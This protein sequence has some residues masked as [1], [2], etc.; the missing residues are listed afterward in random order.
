MATPVEA[1][2]GD[3]RVTPE[4]VAIEVLFGA[5][6]AEASRKRPFSEGARERLLED[7]NAAFERL[8]DLSSVS[9]LRSRPWDNNL[10]VARRSAVIWW[11][12]ALSSFVR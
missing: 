4:M 7:A 6:L 9:R 3:L 1:A 10:A 5:F 8:A 12:G 2:D 11:R